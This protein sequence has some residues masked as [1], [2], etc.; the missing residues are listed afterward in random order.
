[1]RS[2]RVLTLLVLVILLGTILVLVP[3]SWLPVQLQQYYYSFFGE[4]PYE[5]PPASKKAALGQAEPFCPDEH[6]DWRKRQPLISED[7]Q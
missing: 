1:M 4:S 3:P 6:P 2:Y 7:R 5:E